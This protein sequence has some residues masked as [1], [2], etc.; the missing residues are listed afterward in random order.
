M[1]C[2]KHNEFIP[3]YDV[4]PA[5]QKHI[6]A[7]EREAVS[8]GH[9]FTIDNLII[10]YDD[11]LDDPFCGKCNSNSL[12][13]DVQKIISINPGAQ[14]WNNDLELETLIFHELGHCF[15]GRNHLNERLPNGDPKSIMIENNISL[16]S[17]CIYPIGG[18]P[19]NNSF[20]RTYYLDELFDESTAV[21]E[22][23]K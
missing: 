2:S 8:R 23:G 16:Y 1:A 3:V 10:Q 5:F 20:K 14:C 19:C 17:P 15:L 21:P 6:D 13:A 7:F 22:W 18:Q 11:K 12:D 4:P 9:S